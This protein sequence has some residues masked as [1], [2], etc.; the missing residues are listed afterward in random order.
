L[1][2]EKPKLNTKHPGHQSLSDKV[3]QRQEIFNTVAIRCNYI[4]GLH[5]DLKEQKNIFEVELK[6]AKRKLKEELKQEVK[7]V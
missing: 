6:E 1:T 3:K 7:E 4:A 2:P 5:K